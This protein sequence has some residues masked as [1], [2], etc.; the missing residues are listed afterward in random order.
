MPVQAA[1]LVLLAID[2][3]VLL[4]KQDQAFQDSFTGHLLNVKPWCKSACA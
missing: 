1:E 2:S 3:A 4:R